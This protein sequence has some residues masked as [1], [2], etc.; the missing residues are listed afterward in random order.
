MPNLNAEIR[1]LSAK[2]AVLRESGFIPAEI[3]GKE[4]KN[5]HISL[6]IKEFLKV[7][8][9]AGENT[10]INLKAGDNT[11]SVLVHDYQVDPVT[12]DFLSVDFLEVKMDEKITAPIPLSFIGESPAVEEQDAVLIKSMDEIE[13]EALPANLPHEIEIDISVLKEL[14]Q[15]IYV[16][17][18]S[19]SGDYEIVT[20][21]D[22][23]I[24]T[25]S[26]PEEEVEE[27]GPT[28]IE[29]IVTEGEEKR[30]EEVKE[31]ETE[32]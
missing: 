32:S 21:A 13:V 10:I 24:A 11:H 23:V 20:D 7:F 29:D 30:A 12:R 27:E 6:P 18:I 2:P 1:E 25:A 8:K 22:N 4:A 16:R 9:E 28:S 15:S 31:A 17:D 5:I 14:D 26:T 19:V 3:Y